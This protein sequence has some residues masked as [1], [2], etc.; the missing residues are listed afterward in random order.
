MESSMKSGFL[1]CC[2]WLVEETAAPKS[3]DTRGALQRLMKI[4]DVQHLS[5]KADEKQPT[6]NIPN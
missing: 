4:P 1:V 3:E 5:A 2:F 6:N